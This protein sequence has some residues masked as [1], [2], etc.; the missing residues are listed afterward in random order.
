M[1]A[2]F[3]LFFVL[4][5]AI[6]T[7]IGPEL[8]AQSMVDPRLNQTS[9]GSS[10]DLSTIILIVEALFGSMFGCERFFSHKFVSQIEE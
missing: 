10:E 9:R 4:V 5:L 1:E 8:R 3:E 6:A 2:F 7:E